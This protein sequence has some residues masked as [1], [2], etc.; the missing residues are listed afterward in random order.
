MIK[1]RDSRKEFEW[2]DG[3]IEGSEQHN[4]L[5]YML[6]KVQLEYLVGLTAHY[7]LF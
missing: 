7:A 1:N 4:K 6:A 2:I 3:K 5:C